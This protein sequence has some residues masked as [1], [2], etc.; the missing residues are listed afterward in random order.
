MRVLGCVAAILMLGGCFREREINVNVPPGKPV[1]VV[2]AYPEAGEPVRLWLSRST[3][4][5]D[6]RLP[7]YDTTA[8]RDSATAI[9]EVLKYYDKLVPYLNEKLLVTDAEVLITY[10]G[11]TD[12]LRYSPPSLLKLAE[13]LGQNKLNY[14]AEYVGS[15][16]LPE[17]FF[18]RPIELRIRWRDQTVFARTQ[19]LPPV[20][21]DTVYFKQDSKGMR[22]IQI[23]WRD[24]NPG[25]TDYWRCIFDA[26]ARDS[27]QAIEFPDDI[28]VGNKLFM[29]TGYDWKQGRQLTVSIERLNP[30]HYFFIESLED[31]VSANFNPFAQPARLASTLGGNA[32][33]VFE[34]VGASRKKIV[35]E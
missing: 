29:A 6:F 34:G 31:A 8:F 12:T 15:R 11:I 17:D 7:D 30:S 35:V 16:P 32:V 33:G 3:P 4:I 2:E 13:A 26:G 25:Q 22:S 20:P 1:L 23:E 5:N 28:A 10:D 21:I 24:P 14:L 9:E 27:M 18:N 19:I